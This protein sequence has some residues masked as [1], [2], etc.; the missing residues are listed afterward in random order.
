MTLL[1]QVSPE[2]LQA[3]CVMELREPVRLLC[4]YS[5]STLWERGH[6]VVEQIFKQSL[7]IKS[8]RCFFTCANAGCFWRLVLSFRIWKNNSELI[9][10][11]Y[12]LA[13][14]LCLADVCNYLSPLLLR[15]FISST[16][17]LHFI[18]FKPLRLKFQGWCSRYYE[19]SI[20][21][22]LFLQSSKSANQPSRPMRSCLRLSCYSQ[23]GS[24][25]SMNVHHRGFYCQSPLIPSV[26]PPKP[27]K[28]NAHLVLFTPW[29]TSYGL[30]LLSLCLLSLFCS[31]TLHPCPILHLFSL[32]ILSFL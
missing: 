28:I 23:S 21:A 9:V 25:S 11:N 22:R 30:S 19:A 18:Y 4:G 20:S 6:I 7:N 15:A 29:A 24:L 16:R 2:T 26:R 5:I 8:V 3:C 14:G 12:W 17:C 10:F 32:F 27:L 1:Q 31:V 13:L